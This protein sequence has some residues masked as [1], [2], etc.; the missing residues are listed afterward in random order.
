VLINT[1]GFLQSQAEQTGQESTEQVANNV[2]LTS[3]YGTANLNGTDTGYVSGVNIVVQLAPGSEPIDLAD[4][5]VELFPEG[6]SSVQID[7]SNFGTTELVD[8]TDT[9][10][11]AIDDADIDTTGT[12][13]GLEAGDSAEIVITT[14]DGSQSTAIL[15]A[16]SPITDSQ[17]GGQVRL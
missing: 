7:G 17:D 1:A 4:A 10:T 12:S 15:S 11:L 5:T 2:Q 8:G 13:S 14:G 3:S 9:A 6:G 16:P